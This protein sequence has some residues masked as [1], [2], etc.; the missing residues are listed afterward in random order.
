MQEKGNNGSDPSGTGR[1]RGYGNSRVVY[2]CLGEGEQA[3][4]RK[5]CH[6][7]AQRRDDAPEQLGKV[8]RSLS[9]GQE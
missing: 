8:S 1:Y 3:E 4:G 7:K 2:L 9:R 6:G 5:N